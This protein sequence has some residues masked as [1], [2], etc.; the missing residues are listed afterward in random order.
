M[1]GTAGMT[2][3]HPML[4]DRLRGSL[5]AMS[6]VGRLS[7]Q[8]D[9]GIGRRVELPAVVLTGYVKN[10]NR[11]SKGGCYSLDTSDELT[12]WPSQD[13]VIAV[14]E[15][16]EEQVR[17]LA[18]TGDRPY[19]SGLH[20]G[21]PLSTS[22]LRRLEDVPLT[23]VGGA[24]Q[25][26]GVDVRIPPG[27]SLII[28]WAESGYVRLLSTSQRVLA[29]PPHRAAAAAAGG[30]GRRDAGAA[31]RA[32]GDAGH[33]AGA[34]T[35]AAGDAAGDGAV[36]AADAGRGAVTRSR[37]PR[38]STYCDMQ[39]AVTNLRAQV[40]DLLP[41]KEQCEQLTRQLSHS[42]KGRRQAE[43]TVEF[44]RGQ[45]RLLDERELAAGRV[46]AEWDRDGE[47]F[48]ALERRE[49]QMLL[50]IE[51]LMAQQSGGGGGGAAGGGGGGAAG[52]GAGGGGWRDRNPCP[53]RSALGRRQMRIPRTFTAAGVRSATRRL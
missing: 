18:T 47:T 22:I 34:A 17:V 1:A 15:A 3:M 14:A 2:K 20:S 40:A 51:R 26:A 36:C 37:Q 6:S 46:W 33:D 5:R 10:H 38:L 53:W 39:V 19:W 28:L 8:S 41:Y 29:R 42:E 21:H 49:R 48:R 7:T 16:T 31:A 4:A 35:H 13:C 45:A 30:A 44:L 43:A 52:A 9:P 50:T 23:V 25:R 27:P 11:S 32:K 12:I 24:M